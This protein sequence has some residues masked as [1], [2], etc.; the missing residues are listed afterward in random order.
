MSA[1][2]KTNIT[3]HGF[4]YPLSAM[5]LR[6]LVNTK[7]ENL[8]EGF[9]DGKL[10]IT[11]RDSNVSEVFQGLI[12]KGFSSVPVINKSGTYGGFLDF[13]DILSYIV[14][15]FGADRLENTEDYWKLIREE[16]NFKRLTVRNLMNNRPFRRPFRAVPKGYSLMSALEPLARE[17]LIHL[18][19]ILDDDRKLLTIITESQVIRMLRRNKDLLGSKAYMPVR[20]MRCFQRS[21]VVSIRTNEDAILGFTKLALNQ[22][23]GLAVVDDNGRLVDN[24][25]MRDIRGI[26][27]D[28]RFF[29]RLSRPVI[30]F[31]QQVKDEFKDSRPWDV[32]W[33]RPDAMISDVLTLFELQRIHRVYVVDQQHKPISVVS[34]KDIIYEILTDV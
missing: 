13:S 5:F 11:N 24:L 23:R 33:C 15:H 17:R 34:L 2:M 20:E 28:A 29:M 8:L 6:F 27:S 25:S 32:V 26:A 1:T 4:D 21:V 14:E 12:E 3:G 31:L 18:I 19:P 9:P 30:S 7:A 22:I 16:D 10:F